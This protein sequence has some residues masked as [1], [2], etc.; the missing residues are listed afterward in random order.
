MLDHPAIAPSG[1]RLASPG[2]IERLI[3]CA[4]GNRRPSK[5]LLCLSLAAPLA[6]AERLLAL[7]GYRNGLLWAPSGDDEY[8]GVG[9][10]RTLSGWGG[11]RFE[12]I[13]DAA[14]RLFD[15]LS[16]IAL[17]GSPAPAPRLVGG[18]AFNPGL[19]RTTIWQGFGA[20][21]FI[22]PRLAY[23]RVAE[24]AWLLLVASA[25]E[26]ASVAGRAR[27]AWE[28]SQALAVLRSACGPHADGSVRVEESVGDWSALV[29]GISGE[30]AA[31]RLEKA[32]AARR[33]AVR[34]ARLPQPALVLERLRHEAPRCTRF[35]LAVGERVFLGAS[36]ECLVRRSGARVNTEALAG[37][38]PRTARD[39]GGSL[40]RSD[41]ACAEHAIVVREI[42]AALAPLCTRLS[43]DVPVPLRLR[44][45]LHLRTRFAGILG[46]PRHVL[47]L[48][49]ALHPTPA[50]GGTPR[51]EALAWLDGHEH[52]DRGFY[53]GPFGSFDGAGDG[54]F[55]VAIRSALV[56]PDVAHL[57]AGAGIVAGSKSATEWAETRWKLRGLMA[58]IGGR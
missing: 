37:S 31:G 22:L 34:G 43:S 2:A 24:R 8:A 18:F 32:V 7:P 40:M 26:L 29:A 1:S 49:A 14:R 11:S 30:I 41:T 48:V 53:G 55:V 17:D 13:R 52:A 58:A 15:E 16:V 12:A 50:V 9:A 27:V 20:A 54:H 21:K 47:D 10:A 4:L 38:M 6:A 51:R 19:P 3:E 42:R 23:A 25:G 46:K 35:A 44:H 39:A 56:Q 36:P 57:F 5:S 33:V 28:A 45:L